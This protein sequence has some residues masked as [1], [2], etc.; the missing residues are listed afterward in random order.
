LL[1]AC[2]RSSLELVSMVSGVVDEL[3]HACAH[4]QSLAGMLDI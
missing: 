4:A 3:E 1:V 2:Q